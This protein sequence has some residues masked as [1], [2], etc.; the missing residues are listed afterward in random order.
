M[1]RFGFGPNQEN[2]QLFSMNSF[3]N[4]AF[5]QY[6]ILLIDT[7]QHFDKLLHQLWMGIKHYNWGLI[8]GSLNRNFRQYGQLKSRVE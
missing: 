7:Y 2:L 3:N 5:Y 8:E 1:F 6:H 4:T